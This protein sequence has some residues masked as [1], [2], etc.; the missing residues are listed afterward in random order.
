MG[1]GW[2]F[3]F[4]ISPLFGL[5]F[6]IISDQKIVRLLKRLP[7]H[8]SLLKNDESDGWIIGY[9]FIGYIHSDNSYGET[10][11]ILYIFTTSSFYKK[12]MKEINMVNDPIKEI[13]EINETNEI[14]QIKKTNEV[15]KKPTT[16]RLYER[17][18]GSYT[19][20][21]YSQREFNVDYFTPRPY[22][23][24]IINDI[25]S[26]YEKNRS[27]VVILHGEIGTGKSMI[28]LLVS[29][30]LSNQENQED[31]EFVNFCDTF[32]PTDP[33]DDFTKLY[34]RIDPTKKNPLILVLEEFDKIIHQIHFDKIKRHRDCP[35][36]I[37]DKATWN[38]FFDRFDRGYYP[39]T[40]IVMT[41]N[42]SPDVINHM[43]PSFIREGRVNQI[44]HVKDKDK[45]M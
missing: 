11:K 42:V 28:P 19:Y 4:I 15:P 21:H 27:N 29:K 43:D 18:G 24:V 13:I 44:F 38:Q 45:I 5:Q 2:S 34:N 1:I 12:K 3:P 33:G 20:L 25:V 41:S 9:P 39:W 7:N 26:F 40:I 10:K 17:E 8:S 23:Q 31:Q 16:I 35:I 37:Y 30:A 22:Q 32:I 14:N 6:Y 36:M